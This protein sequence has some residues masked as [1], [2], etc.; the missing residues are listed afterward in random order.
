LDI[1]FT[2]GNVIAGLLFS[3]VGF[4]ALLR[5]KKQGNFREMLLGGLLLV[6]PYFVS[7]TPLM[8]AIGSGLTAALF[9]WRD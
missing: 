4:V 2:A 5:G 1:D 6:Y 8:W 7:R 9:F 3:G